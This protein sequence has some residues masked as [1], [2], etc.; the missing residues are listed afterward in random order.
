[1]TE[2]SSR[3]RP[4]LLAAVALGAAL[5]VC[6]CAGEPKTYHVSGV[7]SWK[8]SPIERGRIN[9]VSDDGRTGPATAE[10]VNGRYELRA[11]AGAKRVEVYNQ[12][13]K[14]YDKVMGQHTFA[15]DVPAEY[16]AETKLRFE[17]QPR[18][19]NVLDLALPQK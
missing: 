14:G 3:T 19:D 9:L 6:G 7:V 4:W 16:N 12:R 17:V 10:I 5:A 15:N 13:D 18:D 8:G 11:T 2:T 1:M